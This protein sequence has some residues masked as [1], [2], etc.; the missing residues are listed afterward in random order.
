[1]N[2]SLHWMPRR[3][4]SPHAVDFGAAAI[5]T[6]K[7]V[8]GTSAF[9]PTLIQL[10]DEAGLETYTSNYRPASWSP[11]TSLIP[12]LFD[13]QSTSTHK[14]GSGLGSG[15]RPTACTNLH[16]VLR[17]PRGDGTESL[18]LVTPLHLTVGSAGP[19]IPHTASTSTSTSGTG[20]NNNSR[21]SAAGSA[22]AAGPHP[23]ST[24]A[25]LCAALNP[26][27]VDAGALLLGTAAMLVRH[28]SDVDWLAKDL[29][30]VVPD[31]R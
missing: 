16:G 28:L 6:A 27:V 1:M 15:A 13:A 25:G 9:L 5:N 3:S 19:H 26:E 21:S 24:A 30:W 4:D 29:I 20:G 2:F 22:G 8:Y 14:Q 11:H 12:L 17:S 7:A 23:N 18:V 31:A 10:M